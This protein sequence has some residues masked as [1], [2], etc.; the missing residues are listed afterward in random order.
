M[1]QMRRI[2][3]RDPWFG[4]MLVAP[5]LIWIVAS[6]LYPLLEAILLSLKNVGYAGTEGRFI[7]LRNYLNLLSQ[8]SFYYS[9]WITLIWT[10]LNVVLQIGSALVGAKIL[11]QDFFGKEFIR[12]WI[13]VP[14]VLPSIVLATLGKWVLDP[15][16]G[17]VNYLLRHLGLIDAPLSFL[18][19]VNLALPWVILL[20]VWRWFPFFVV[21]FLAALQTVPKELFEAAEIDQAGFW[22][23]FIY[24]ELPGIM[25]ILKVQVLLC[26]LWAVNIFDTIWLLTRGGP[27]KT[28]T[29]LPVLIYLKAFQEYRISQSSALAVLMFVIL[30][31]GSFIYF[32]RSLNV[33]WEEEKQ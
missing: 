32:R 4:L 25:P 24:V 29:T 11:N 20:N 31:I 21:M 5:I 23:K 28:T 2:L 15:S 17:I 16:L 10:V 27:A 30:L 19:D 33:D 26:I 14:W 7:G 8:S 1:K 18:S 22:Q 6:L 3:E 13:I 12:N 9:L